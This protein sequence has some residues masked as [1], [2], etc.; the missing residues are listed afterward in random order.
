M[1]AIGAVRGAAGKG[2][3]LLS[4]LIRVR[5]PVSFADVIGLRERWSIHVT[6][7]ISKGVGMFNT[8]IVVTIELDAVPGSAIVRR[9][10]RAGT[11]VLGHGFKCREKL[12][13]TLRRLFSMIK[14]RKFS[15]EAQNLL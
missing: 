5:N 2:Q 1:E 4:H 8:R 11:S 9:Q 3:G 13:L 15:A 7:Y 14:L 6:P 10:T 12:Y